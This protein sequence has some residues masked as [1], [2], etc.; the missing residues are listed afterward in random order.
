MNTNYLATLDNIMDNAGQWL[1][2]KEVAKRLSVHP[3]TI[4][5]WAEAGLIKCVRHPINNYRL[6]LMADLKSREKEND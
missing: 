6:F 4:R 3:D 2:V 5:R 1:T